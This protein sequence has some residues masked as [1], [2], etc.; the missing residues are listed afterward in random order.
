MSNG[1]TTE[2]MPLAK[3]E[4]GAIRVGNTRVTLESIVC[5]FDEGATPEEIVQQYPSVPLADIYHVVGYYLRHAAE[6]EAYVR[7][8]L[9]AKQLVRN[10]NEARWNAE[11]IRQRLMARHR[12]Q[13]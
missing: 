4:D 9:S 3:G 8:R 13:A 2:A 7:Q 1:I 11:G 5:A 12:I 6:V 10:E